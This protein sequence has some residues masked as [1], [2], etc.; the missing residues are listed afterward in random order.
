[1][2]FCGAF[3]GQGHDGEP[4]PEAIT[5][6]ALIA[7][8]GDLPAGATEL[9]CHPAAGGVPAMPY[10]AERVRELAALCDPGVRAAI[11]EDGVRLCTFREALR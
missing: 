11:D 9:C 2:R 5:A 8:V 1:V 10:G 6:D 3:Y 7:L 4:L